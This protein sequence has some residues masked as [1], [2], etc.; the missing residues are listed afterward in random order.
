MLLVCYSSRRTI[1]AFQKTRFLMGEEA[2][3]LIPDSGSRGWGK[4][5]RKDLGWRTSA[6]R[7]SHSIS[8][9]H[10]QEHQVGISYPLPLSGA[11]EELGKNWE[12]HSVS[13]QRCF[14]L[15]FLR[16]VEHQGCQESNTSAASH[17]LHGNLTVALCLVVNKNF[18]P[19][20]VSL[21]WSGRICSQS[22]CL[23]AQRAT[24][25]QQEEGNKQLLPSTKSQCRSSIMTS[26]L[27]CYAE[28]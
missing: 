24:Q 23:P 2:P 25:A 5:L 12:T 1:T 3:I 27:D 4:D 15:M 11:D 20:F 7:L 10:I 21:G 22:L 19:N 14:H 26:H 16:A 18:A 9:H 28:L 13:T 8:S 17:G 6:L